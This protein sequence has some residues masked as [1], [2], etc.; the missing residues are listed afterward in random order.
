MPPSPAAALTAVGPPA[1]SVQSRMPVSAGAEIE[2]RAP[3]HPLPQGMLVY[4]SLLPSLLAQQRMDLVAVC[5]LCCALS[6]WPWALRR[7]KHAR[8][9]RDCVLLFQ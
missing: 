2:E 7:V 6:G 3:P 9:D 5:L 8:V 4:L 1:T